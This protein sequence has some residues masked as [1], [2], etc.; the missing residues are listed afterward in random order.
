MRSRLNSFVFVSFTDTDD[1]QDD[2]DAQ[3]DQ[4]CIKVRGDEVV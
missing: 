1:L 2:E 4:E 3:A